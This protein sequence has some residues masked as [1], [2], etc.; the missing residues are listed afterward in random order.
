[1]GRTHSSFPLHKFSLFLSLSETKFWKQ[2]VTA[3]CHEDKSY[4]RGIILTTPLHFLIT[5]VG[6]FHLFWSRPEVKGTLPPKPG[7]AV[8]LMGSSGTGTFLFIL[9]LLSK[10]QCGLC[11]CVTLVKICCSSM[12]F[13]HLLHRCQMRSNRKRA[14]WL[15]LP[16]QF[17]YLL[18]LCQYIY[19]PPPMLHRSSK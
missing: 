8:K 15:L 7:Q 2:T 14:D 16:M 19:L 1:M 6:T 4:R 3:S 5:E 18:L 11:F 9:S 10:N 17:S 13:C 12:W